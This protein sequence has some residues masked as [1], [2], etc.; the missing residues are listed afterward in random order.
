MSLKVKVR[1]LENGRLKKIPVYA[2]SLVAIAAS[3]FF[4]LTIPETSDIVKEQNDEKVASLEQAMVDLSTVTKSVED[5]AT[6]LEESEVSLMQA[7]TFLSE[8]EVLLNTYPSYLPAG[9]ELVNEELHENM[10]VLHYMNGEDALLIQKVYGEEELE[11]ESVAVDSQEDGGHKEEVRNVGRVTKKT[12]SVSVV[13]EG[14]LS[15][16]ELMNVS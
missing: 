10:H 12:E 4:V 5:D 16:K 3:V 9:Y 6:L 8:D 14:V 7:E 1:R 15:E 11:S 13:V 2:S